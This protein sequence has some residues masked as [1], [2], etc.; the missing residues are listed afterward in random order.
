MKTV[1]EEVKL[2]GIGSVK[3]PKQAGFKPGVEEREGVMDEQSGESDEEEVMGK[4]IGESEMEELVLVSIDVYSQ[5]LLECWR[6]ILKS[7]DA[8][9][10]CSASKID[11]MLTNFVDTTMDCTVEMTDCFIDG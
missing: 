9:F 2:R 3:Q 11:T 5:T 8:F 6:G 7:P 10:G 1:R 4:G